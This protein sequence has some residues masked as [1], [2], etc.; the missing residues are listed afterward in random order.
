M[1]KFK[2]QRNRD[3]VNNSS[4]ESLKIRSIFRLFRCEFPKRGNSAFA[5][6]FA[7][8]TSSLLV[9]IGVSIFNISLKELMIATTA[10]DSQKAYYAADSAEECAL[11]WD[12]K[13]G[14]FPAC[15]N[16]NCDR[17]NPS[18]VSTTTPQSNIKCNGNNVSLYFNKP[19]NLTFSTST[20]KFFK[21]GTITE[22]ES[23]ISIRKEF[24]PAAAPYNYD[25]IKT[26]ITSQGHNT[27]I[28]GRRVERGIIQSYNQ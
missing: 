23:D 18:D 25:R 10:Q 17:N 19:D 11:Y 3:G 12:L 9:A 15:L 22:P 24:I 6:L 5:M 7:V 27:G 20:V 26:T 16:N 1:N 28:L 4:S 8:L 2:L 13:M 21:Y 14:A